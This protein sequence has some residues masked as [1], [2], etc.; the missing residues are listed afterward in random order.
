MTAFKMSIKPITSLLVLIL[1]SS[2]GS[3]KDAMYSLEEQPPFK[4]GNASYQPWVAGVQ[5]GGKGV[6]IVLD[7]TDIQEAVAIKAVYFQ[8][9]VCILRN[10][11]SSIDTFT[12]SFNE[13]PK[14]DVVM[15]GNPVNESQNT[16]VGEFPFDLKDNEAVVS[17]TH[18]GEL[19]FTKISGLEKKP[20]LSY[21]SSNPN[22]D[23]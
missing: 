12:G 22:K 14:K 15:D 18:N 7:I 16:P 6:N 19:H 21:P 10:D 20:E 8:E 5:E 9:H 2:C 13:R 4:I 11:M 3:G 1:L 23:Y 17:Y